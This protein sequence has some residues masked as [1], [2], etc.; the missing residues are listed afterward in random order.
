LGIPQRDWGTKRV[1]CGKHLAVG[2]QGETA[3][4]AT[5]AELLQLLT[6]DHVP[7]GDG[8]PGPRGES[9]AV[10]REG[11]GGCADRHLHL[12]QWL[13]SNRIPGVHRVATAISQE[14]FAIRGRTQRGN[15]SVVAA[16]GALNFFAGSKLEL[17]GAI[18]A[19]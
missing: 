16:I 11:H 8:P 3:Y 1:A 12:P 15:G 18:A 9:L 19:Q 7:D 13:A 5:I 2:R 17:A 6:S 10:A 4:S 14:R